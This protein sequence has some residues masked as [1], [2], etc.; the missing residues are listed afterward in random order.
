MPPKPLRVDVFQHVPFEGPAA[1]GEWLAG[2]GHTVTLR[3][4]WE[5]PPP[6]PSRTDL[7]VIMGGPMSVTDTSTH[8]WLADEIDAVRAHLNRGTP[9]IGVCLGAQL[10]AAALGGAVYP[11]AQKEIGWWPVSFAGDEDTLPGR[12]TVLHWHG[13]TFDL[14]RGARRIASS[15]VCPNQAFRY[16]DHAVALQ[17]HLESTKAS[18][19]A[20]TRA[21][22]HEIGVGTWQVARASALAA[23]VRGEREFGGFTRA[24]LTD[25]LSELE[26][27]AV[28]RAGTTAE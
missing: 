26:G 8:P 22:A 5:A 16:G 9:T 21:S 13:D 2:R 20:L 25:L 1:I 10:I 19:E 7:L 3:R 28:R 14:P 15:P 6:P 27:L 11:A 23:M 17:F 12:L 18:V 24:V 4:M